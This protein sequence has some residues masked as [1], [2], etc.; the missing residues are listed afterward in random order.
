MSEADN[1]VLFVTK[2]KN[3]WIEHCAKCALKRIEETT[4]CQKS[5]QDDMIKIIKKKLLMIM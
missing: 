2:D 3:D 1:I 4:M 5:W